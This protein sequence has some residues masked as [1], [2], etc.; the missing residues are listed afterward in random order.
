MRRLLV[1][2]VAAAAMLFVAFLV[3][4]YG[5]GTVVERGSREEV[6]SIEVDHGAPGAPAAG[7]LMIPVRGIAPPML[8][9]T[10]SQGRAD[11]A[12]RHD[13]IDIIAPAGAPVI[14]AAPGIVER[15]FVSED[16]GNTVY[17]RSRDGRLV[18]YY[19]HLR[20]YARGLRE[21]AAVERGTFLGAVGATGNAD[22]AAPHL[23]F[24]IHR[25][26]PGED[27]WEGRPINP[28]PLLARSP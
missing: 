20:G 19:A 15:L 21:G 24:A 18:Y 3:W 7:E 8:F 9:D 11:G 2:I 12:R 4:I 22:P 28:Y 17:V 5:F 27:W 26:S 14:A 25:M 1:T 23:H 6:G 10:F 13:A 16:G